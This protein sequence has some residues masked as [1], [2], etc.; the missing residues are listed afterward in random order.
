M[1][2]DSYRTAPAMDITLDEFE[3]YAIARLKGKFQPAHSPHPSSPDQL[4]STPLIHPT[5]YFVVLCS[6]HALL[7]RSLP[8]AQFKELAQTSIKTNLP[9]SSNTA[10]NAKLDEE[11]RRDEIG[12]W[13]LTLAFSRR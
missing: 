6:I 1:M 11:R 2:C 5:G 10:R 3:I 4:P 12:H 13:V 9:L 8:L 7:D